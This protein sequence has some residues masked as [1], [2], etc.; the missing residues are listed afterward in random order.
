M[1]KRIVTALIMIP[2]AMAAIIYLPEKFFTFFIAG[3]ALFAFF[4]ILEMY[5][6]REKLLF[7]VSGAGVMFTVYYG[8]LIKTLPYHF[9]ISLGSSLLAISVLSMVGN[10]NLQQKAKKL[11]VHTLAFFYI[12]IPMIFFPLLRAWG[13]N[14][15]KWFIFA[16]IMPWLCDS[17]AF[18]S[19]SKFGKHKMSPKISPNKSWEGAIGGFV[20]SVV[21]AVVYKYLFLPDVFLPFIMIAG[22]AASTL[23]Q[24][25]DLAESLIKRDAGSKDSGSIFPGHGGMFDRIDSLLFSVVTVYIFVVIESLLK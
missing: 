1:I 13:E 5:G 2:L 4:E 18:F 14:G 24:L 17:G 10:D 23:G 12:S 11:S 7:L 16:L 9:L 21:G 15:L 20:V 25:G 22:G 3:I 6:V 19:G 8:S